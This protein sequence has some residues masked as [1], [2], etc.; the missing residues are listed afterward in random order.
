MNFRIT[1]ARSQYLKM[2]KLMRK[3]VEHFEQI[4]ILI[5]YLATIS[6]F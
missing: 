5:F 6:F 4:Y 3:N 2:D 1:T